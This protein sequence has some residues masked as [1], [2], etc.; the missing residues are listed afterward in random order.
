MG[1]RGG[2]VFYSGWKVDPANFQLPNGSFRVN[3]LAVIQIV[4]TVGALVVGGQEFDQRSAEANQDR[5]VDSSIPD[6]GP[7]YTAMDF[8]LPGVLYGVPNS[9]VS[10]YLSVPNLPASGGLLTTI[11]TPNVQVYDEG[12]LPGEFP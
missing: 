11:D 12:L 4:K 2:S 6:F 9:P 5:H 8:D 3:H 10:E 7:L 1:T